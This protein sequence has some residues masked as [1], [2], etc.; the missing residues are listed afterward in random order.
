MSIMD[1]CPAISDILFPEER[2]RVLKM[3]DERDT[4]GRTLVGVSL[5]DVGVEATRGLGGLSATGD[6]VKGESAFIA[7]WA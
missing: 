7:Y 5:G 4:G 6:D 3:E 1:S 2:R